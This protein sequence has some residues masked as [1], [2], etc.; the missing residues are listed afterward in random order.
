[1]SAFFFAFLATLLALVA[2]RDSL[3]VARLAGS[4]G[5]TG[6]LIV[7]IGLAAAGYAVLAALLAR[8]MEAVLPASSAR[9][10]VAAAL[11]VAGV[12][13]LVLRA[14]ARPVEPTRSV[15]AI[16]LVLCA[17]L[18]FGAAGFLVI[19]LATW[20]AAPAFAA[21][22]GAGGAMVALT[23]AASTGPDWEKLP[24]RLFRAS[25]GWALLAGA[26]VTGYLALVSPE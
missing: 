12:E 14:G 10:L 9:L 21:A 6:A 11:L 7:A 16:G 4:L 26:V 24:L 18:L 15:A 2:G 19:A 13:V 25:I 23:L 17:N 5:S 20:S 1:M 3:R 22:G 8:G